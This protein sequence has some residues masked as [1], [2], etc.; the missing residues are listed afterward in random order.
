M[1]SWK[2]LQKVLFSG[3]LYPVFNRS[4]DLDKHPSFLKND[5][6]QNRL[7][8]KKYKC[9]SEEE[10]PSY[11]LQIHYVHL[12]P[13]GWRRYSHIDTLLTF[14]R[15]ASLFCPPSPTNDEPWFSRGDKIF[16]KTQKPSTTETL[17]SLT[18]KHLEEEPRS[19]LWLWVWRRHFQALEDICLG[20]INSDSSVKSK[21][22]DFFPTESLI[23][24]NKQSP[25]EVSQFGFVHFIVS[26][27]GSDSL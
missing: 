25:A 3:D 23:P 11:W 9:T 24:Q 17:L 5:V 6:E 4:D 7:K 20:M 1:K 8:N 2:K 19:S 10:E 26:V 21:C 18:K 16:A 15:A 13:A 12:N 14:R 27:S 22:E